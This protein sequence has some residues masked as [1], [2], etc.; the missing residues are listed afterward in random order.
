MTED[1][2][3]PVTPDGDGQPIDGTREITGFVTYAGE[4][5][6][7]VRPKPE[8]GEQPVPTPAS[9]RRYLR[10]GLPGLYRDDDFT[11]RF[12][13]AL[14]HVLDPVVSLLDTLPAHFDPELAPLDI[15]ALSTGW[16][17]LR[18]NE[19]QPAS[20]LRELVGRAAELGRLRGTHAGVELALKLNFPDLAAADRGRRPSPLVHWGRAARPRAPRLRRLL[21]HPDLEGRGVD[22]RSRHRGREACPRGV[23]AASQGPEA[24]RRGILSA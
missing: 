13:G 17:G 10:D 6:A 4:G 7:L 14:E 24:P 19:A 1:D 12:V 15:L 11:M 18:H 9:N 21:R 8:T 20:Q 5:F 22:D 2:G 3:Q 23:P 16:L